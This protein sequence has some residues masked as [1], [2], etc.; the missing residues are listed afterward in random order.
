MQLG[1]PPPMD[2]TSNIFDLYYNNLFV[3][4]FW[5]FNIVYHRVKKITTLLSSCFLFNIDKIDNITFTSVYFFHIR[6]LSTILRLAVGGWPK[7]YAR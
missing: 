1:G 2:T 5:S 3:H 6:Q 4:S 7:P